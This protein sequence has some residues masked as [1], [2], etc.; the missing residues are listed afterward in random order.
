MSIKYKCIR[1]RLNPERPAAHAIQETDE[2]A[3]MRIGIV[4]RCDSE[5]ATDLA[6]E[7][8]RHLNGRAQTIYDDETAQ[9]LGE[10]GI[11]LETFDVDVIVTV[12]GDG[13]ILRVLQKLRH[14]I[15]IVGINV[16]K[17]GF[18][19]D[20]S[21]ER[22]VSVVEN[23]LGGFRVSAHSRLAISVNDRHLPPATNEAVIITSRPAK[24]LEYSIEIDDHVVDVLR[25]DGVIVATPTGS[26][27]Y[28]MSAGGPI[29]DPRVNA[30]LIV[31]LAPHKLSIRP[32]V[33]NDEGTV[34]VTIREK[35]AAIVVDGQYSETVHKDD[36]IHFYK[37][38]EESLFVLG[39]KTFFEKVREKLR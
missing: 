15:P 19:A 13:T 29:V 1:I 38:Q 39:E 6:A 36:E 26:T 32:W 37:D 30:F 25:A 7:M 9:A 33:V 35:D 28:A 17:V 16:G 20:V 11:P 27:A 12:G 23:L 34:A 2:Y 4:S 24:I 10:K 22:A 5:E 3:K 21:P 8:G 18:L 31:P 14:P